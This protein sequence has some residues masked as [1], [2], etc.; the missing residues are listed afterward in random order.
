MGSSS[1]KDEQEEE[2][3]QNKISPLNAARNSKSPSPRIS[4]NE[5]KYNK[6]KKNN[7]NHYNQAELQG[8]NEDENQYR[9][10]QGDYSPEGKN[11]PPFFSGWDKKFH[12]NDKIQLKIH[13]L[14]LEPAYQLKNLKKK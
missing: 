9:L 5:E 4:M 8:N 2:N 10:S 7:E 6:G 11:D 14:G 13:I 12:S 1:T 3:N